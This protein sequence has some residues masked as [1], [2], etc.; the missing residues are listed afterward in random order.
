M[1]LATRI[2]LLA[3]LALT[4]AQALAGR[5]R[6]LHS[7]G[8][9]TDG[10]WP[11]CSL[12]ALNG[13]LYGTTSSGGQYGYGTI[14]SITPKGKETTLHNFGGVALGDGSVPVTGLTEHGGILYGVTKTGGANSNLGTVF[15]IRAN[16]TYQ[17]ILKFAN[18]V[19]GTQPIGSL[20]FAGGKLYGTTS[21]GGRYQLGNLF[22]VTLSGKEEVLHSFV[23]PDDG[24]VPTSGVVAAHGA[25]Y[26][27]TFNGGALGYGV[28]FT[29]SNGQETVA[30]TFGDNVNIVDGEHPQ[31][32]PMSLR[33]GTVYGVTTL[34]G[35]YGRGAIYSIAAA[36]TES[37]LYSF[38][39]IP[40]G[41]NPTGP[42]LL[43]GNRV[44]GTTMEGGQFNEGTIY[45]FAFGGSEEVVHSFG[46]LSDASTPQGGLISVNG[47]LYGTTT[48]GGSYSNGTVYSFQP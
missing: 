26:G 19:A 6:I 22:S 11:M 12:S 9:G 33:K 34:G 24:I 7:F 29:Y 23:G 36:G 8:N 15:S 16:G 44:Y 3:C 20:A 21:L 40:D 45:R 47:V 41:M 25:I 4:P 28:A 17:I 46:L 27:N 38:L 13:V 48:F 14:F 31:Y 2:V 30:H 32:S 1:N 43:V 5:Y 18:Y 10:T 39:G 35:N 42:L 37:I